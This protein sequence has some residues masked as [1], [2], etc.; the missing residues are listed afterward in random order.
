M[1]KIKMATKKP[2]PKVAA[3]AHNPR[4]KDGFAVLD[5]KPHELLLAGTDPTLAER[6]DDL[7]RLSRIRRLRY[8]QTV[9]ERDFEDDLDLYDDIPEEGLSP[10][11]IEGEGLSPQE[12]ALEEPDVSGREEPSPSSSPAEQSGEA[13]NGG[14]ATAKQSA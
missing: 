3:K 14:E 9:A 2:T 10:Y 6:V 8:N 7:T 4:V 11:E 12:A 13:A 1:S 5:E